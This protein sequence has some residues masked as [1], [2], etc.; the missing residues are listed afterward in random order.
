MH[1]GLSG[2]RLERAAVA[3]EIWTPPAED[4]GGARPYHRH[5]LTSVEWVDLIAAVIIG[6]LAVSASD[7]NALRSDIARLHERWR[8]SVEQR[9]GVAADAA[10]DAAAAADEGERDGT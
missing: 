3:L 7:L 9:A 2:A 5:V 6:D 8:A 1:Y 4:G 10:D